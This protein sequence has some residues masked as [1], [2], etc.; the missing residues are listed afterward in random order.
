MPYYRFGQ[1]DIF[2]NE[3]ETHPRVDFHF[4]NGVA[5]LNRTQS[6][7]AE[8]D[9]V[10]IPNHPVPGVTFPAQNVTH[11]PSGYLSLHELNID[12]KL[13]AHDYD[14]ET[15]TGDE[16]MIYP[17]ITKSGSLTS[18]KTVS[19]STF[20]SFNYGMIMTSSYP[21]SASV[22]TEHYYASGS[23]G[24]LVDCYGD[25]R[26]H[27][28]SLKNTLNNYLYL[29]R[30]FSYENYDTE[31]V[32]LVN[33]PSIFYGSHIEK[34]TVELKLFY[35][36]EMIAKLSDYKKNGELIQVYPG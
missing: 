13:S 14:A 15:E 29:S 32:R 19:T 26:R 31:E 8:F 36:G 24:E 1:N 28:R 2:R 33:I 34:G 27:L 11:V 20:Q 35:M 7:L 25:V 3:I 5:Y 23:S 4:H 12:R 10:D 16:T 9:P 17:F 21:L 18:F 22:T 30:E 6:Q